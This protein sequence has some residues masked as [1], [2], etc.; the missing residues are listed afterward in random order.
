VFIAIITYIIIV[1]YVDH[2]GKDNTV[3]IVCDKDISIEQLKRRLYGLFSQV[4]IHR[5]ISIAEENPM[6]L[7]LVDAVL[8]IS[9]GR[10]L[11]GDFEDRF[12]CPCKEIVN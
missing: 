8:E 6:E 2:V 10:T 12:F 11:F 1:K 9:S 5:D 4:I 7:F 3:C